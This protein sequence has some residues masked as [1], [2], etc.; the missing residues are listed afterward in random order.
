M[1]TTQP[2]SD[3]AKQHNTNGSIIFTVSDVIAMIT[4][5][6]MEGEKHSAI[7]PSYNTQIKFL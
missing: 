4:S 2:T 5:V 1:E 6:T 7:E 3:C